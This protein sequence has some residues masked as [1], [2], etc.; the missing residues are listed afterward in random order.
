MQQT[1]GKR[2]LKLNF[3]KHPNQ[4][5]TAK[6]DAAQLLQRLAQRKLALFAFTKRLLRGNFVHEAAAHNDNAPTLVL[7]DKISLLRAP[8]ISFSGKDVGV[9]LNGP[10]QSALIKVSPKNNEQP[11]IQY[12]DCGGQELVAATV[13]G[14][15]RR[16][17]IATKDTEP[18]VRSSHH[19]HLACCHCQANTADHP[20]T[21]IARTRAMRHVCP[22][23]ES[24]AGV[25]VT[26]SG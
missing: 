6:T 25:A 1:V 22:H 11:R 9:V 26:D 2:G 13:S 7:Q 10:R 17:N 14:C 16:Q 12:F 21:E 20:R 24:V 8:L 23:R 3:Q 15:R 18:S 19:H 5:E 4:V